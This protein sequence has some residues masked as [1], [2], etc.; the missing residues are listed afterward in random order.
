MTERENFF[1]VYNH[2][3]PAWTPN[4]FTAYSPMGTSL[5]NN[6]GEMFKGGKDMFGCEWLCTEDTGF[7]PIPDPNKHMMEVDDIT[8]WQDF[9]KFPDINDFDWEE[10]ARR[11]L[12]MVDKENKVFCFFGMEGNFNRLQA[13]MGTCDAMIAMLEEPEAVAEFFEAHTKFRMKMVEQVAQYYKPDIFVSGDD[14]CSGSG[15]FFSKDM[16]DELIKPYEKMFAECIINNGMICE[17]HICGDVSM[18]ID[19]IVNTGA[20]IWQTAQP[21]NDLVAYE[22]KYGDR[23]LAHGGWDS[24]SQAANF[25]GCKE[26]DVRAEVR[27]SIDKYLGENGHYMLFPVVLGDRRRKDIQERMFWISD[28]CTR[29]SMEKLK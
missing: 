20:T 3:T 28:E 14:V 24:T 27:N 4:F 15:L 1:R 2:Q 16:Y 9:I 19:D 22:K 29:Y 26:E 10:G 7:Q 12:Q 11:D 25:D 5:I 13:M 21:M 23:I 6:T 8:H 18:I 17:H